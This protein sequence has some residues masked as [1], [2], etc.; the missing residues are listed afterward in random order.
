MKGC[1]CSGEQRLQ[2]SLLGGHRGASSRKSCGGWKKRRGE[3]RLGRRGKGVYGEGDGKEE[4]EKDW[5]ADS[6]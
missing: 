6:K 2:S 1:G 4:G 5:Q 3:K